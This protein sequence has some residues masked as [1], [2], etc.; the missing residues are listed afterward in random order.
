M[1]NYP[2]EQINSALDFLINE[3]N[4]YIVDSLGRLGYLTNVG[5]YYMFQPVEIENKNIPYDER[6]V[7][8]PYK[9]K[10]MTIKLLD[11]IKY[12]Q[13]ELP[14][15]EKNDLLNLEELSLNTKT[16]TKTRTKRENTVRNIYTE[17]EK[18]YQN[19]LEPRNVKS[20]EK[21]IWSK[22]AALTIKN[23]VKFH[24]NDFDRNIC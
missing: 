23:L 15:E 5:D 18:D 22:Y 6:S 20:S 12:S 17:I 16:K 9:R 19:L 10:Q 21:D 8:I 4:E 1:K 24:P 13:L 11:N 3:K 14:E 7:P 2:L